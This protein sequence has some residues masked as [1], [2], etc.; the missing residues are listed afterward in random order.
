MFVLCS[1]EIL[2]STKVCTTVNTVIRDETDLAWRANF[3]N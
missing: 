1:F 2:V 3:A